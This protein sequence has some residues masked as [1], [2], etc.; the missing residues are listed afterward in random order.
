M[1]SYPEIFCI[2]S[3]SRDVNKCT[4]QISRGEPLLC[5]GSVDFIKHFSLSSRQLSNSTA[6]LA[7]VPLVRPF[8][9]EGSKSC[10]SILTVEVPPLHVSTSSRLDPEARNS[11]RRVSFRG[12]PSMVL[13]SHC[14]VLVGCLPLSA[15]VPILPLMFLK[16]SFCTMFV[17]PSISHPFFLTTLLLAARPPLMGG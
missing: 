17:V 11:G 12:V 2:I 16:L 5:K 6:V 7:S 3:R 10:S 8:A 9:F 14:Y 13:T 1:C 4:P 15:E